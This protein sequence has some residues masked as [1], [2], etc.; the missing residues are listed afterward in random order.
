ME[1]QNKKIQY[2]DLSKP[3]KFAVV[4][5]YIL[6]IWMCW[7]LFGAFWYIIRS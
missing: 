1:E 5:A 4:F 2:K 7:A 3:L 6:F